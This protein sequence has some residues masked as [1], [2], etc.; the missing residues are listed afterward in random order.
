MRIEEEKQALPFKALT[1]P[2]NGIFFFFFLYTFCLSKKIAI[3]GLES[4]VTSLVESWVK[5]QLG[6]SY[7]VEDID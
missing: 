2:S 3:N 1:N 5:L 4:N 6:I 7:S